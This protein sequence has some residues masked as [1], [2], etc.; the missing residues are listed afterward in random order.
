MCCSYLYE[1]GQ[2]EGDNVEVMAEI[3]LS[4]EAYSAMQPNREGGTY[5]KTDTKSC[6]FHSQSHH[7]NITYKKGL[8]SKQAEYIQ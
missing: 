6:S 1:G 3:C 4:G 2:E 7:T 8:A 5:N